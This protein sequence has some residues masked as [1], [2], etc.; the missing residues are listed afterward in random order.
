[1]WWVR[2]WEMKL[3]IPHGDFNDGTRI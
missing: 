1:M 3:A 2:E